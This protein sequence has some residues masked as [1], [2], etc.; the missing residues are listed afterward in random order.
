MKL[1]VYRG[2]ETAAIPGYAKL[3]GFLAAGD[4]RS[5]EVKKVGDNL[6]RARLD[7]SNRLLFSL[8][9]HG[10]ESYALILE[11]I[12]A[13]AYEKSRFLARG[14]AIEEDR[15]PAVSADA[16]EGEGLVNRARGIEGVVA[17]ALVP[18]SDNPGVFRC[19]LRS[20]GSVDVRSVAAERS[21]GGHRNAA[22]CRVAGTWESAKAEIA[23]A[24]AA[25]VAGEPR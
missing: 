3:A 16:A 8:Y 1:L 19:S 12:P 9:R 7:R 20:T 13:H 15:I 4:F 17:A 25:A 2:L 5:A 6:Y 23:S 22:G 10:G 21:G 24:L 11:Y 18:E 14:A